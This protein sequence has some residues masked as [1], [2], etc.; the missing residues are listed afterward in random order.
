M[1]A[2]AL[3]CFHEFIVYIRALQYTHGVHKIIIF[4]QYLKIFETLKKVEKL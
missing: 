2:A 3:L 1:G 4:L